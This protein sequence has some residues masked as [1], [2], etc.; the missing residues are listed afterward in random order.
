MPVTTYTIAGSLPGNG[1]IFGTS[2]QHRGFRLVSNADLSATNPNEHDLYLEGG[3]LQVVNGDRA[4]AQEIKTRLLFF[5]GESFA[6]LLEGVP[7]FQEILIKGVDENRV[8]SIIKQAILSVPTIVD[9]ESITFELDRQT[10]SA[11]VEWSA[12]TNVN[13]VIS[14]EDFGPLI[15]Q[16]EN[17]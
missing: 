4:T 9:V 14:S 16:E 15:I 10:R 12:R 5:K 2:V 17:K 11:T 3:T 8:K 6:N 7:Y 1:N 13:T